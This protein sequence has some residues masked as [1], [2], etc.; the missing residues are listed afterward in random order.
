M[1][2]KTQQG[3]MKNQPV[4]LQDLKKKCYVAVERAAPS[5]INWSKTIGE[6]TYGLILPTVHEPNNWVVKIADKNRV[7]YND[8][9]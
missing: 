1:A 7:L 2:Q 3:L 5:S 6:G 4:K 9:P 8:G